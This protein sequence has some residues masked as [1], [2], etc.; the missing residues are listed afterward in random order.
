VT[1]D[2]FRRVLV[3]AD[4]TEHSQLA[5]DAAITIAKKFNSELHCIGVLPPQ[6]AETEA[7]GFGLK[8]LEQTRAS[9]REQ[10]G[11]CMDQARAAEIQAITKLLNGDAASVIEDYALR[12]TIDMIVVGHHHLNRLRRFLEGSTSEGL[13]EHSSRSILVVRSPSEGS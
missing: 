13:V 3:G 8:Q 7:E 12:N 1:R 5:I 11:L 2:L 9:I 10:V 6:S 4:G